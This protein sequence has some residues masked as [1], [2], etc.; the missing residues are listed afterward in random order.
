MTID[1]VCVVS[2]TK[3]KK[4][5]A[6]ICSFVTSVSSVSTSTIR[7]YHVST[8]APAVSNIDSYVSPKAPPAVSTSLT[9]VSRLGAS[10]AVCGVSLSSGVRKTRVGVIP[11]RLA[12]GSHILQMK[13][14]ES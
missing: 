7:A 9:P 2:G 10:G 11:L 6:S 1:R 13:N 14:M 4:I 3:P 8:T 5:Q 12:L